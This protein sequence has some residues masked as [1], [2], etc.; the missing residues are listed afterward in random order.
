MRLLSFIGK[1]VVGSTA[2]TVVGLAVPAVVASSPL[3]ASATGPEFQGQLIFKALTLF[4]APVLFAYLLLVPSAL[5]LLRR[6]TP[7][8]LAV[9]MIIPAVLFIAVS[10]WFLGGGGLAS[11]AAVF[12]LTGL[13]AI[14]CMASAGAVWWLV[15][16]PDR[17]SPSLDGY[18]GA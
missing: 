3:S 7:R 5:F 2:G 16:R 11:S 13:P 17:A 8:T 9:A 6:L 12:L 4:V 15:V 10:L 1:F 14:A 18:A